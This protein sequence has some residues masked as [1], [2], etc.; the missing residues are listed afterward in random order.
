MPLEK[1]AG[2]Q[3][4]LDK[5][6]HIFLFLFVLWETHKYSQLATPA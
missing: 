4:N 2:L 3:S 5:P 6:L 1:G